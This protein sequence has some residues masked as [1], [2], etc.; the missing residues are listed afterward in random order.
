M[1]DQSEYVRHMAASA[2]GEHYRSD[3]QTLPLLRER[4]E[5]DPTPWLRE[6]AKQLA[7]ELAAKA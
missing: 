6:R 1:K 2:I 5:N 7:D 4:A 3:A